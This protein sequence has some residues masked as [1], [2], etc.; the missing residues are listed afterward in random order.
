MAGPTPDKLLQ[1]A[2][3]RTEEGRNNA[4]FWLA[5]QLHD[6]EYVYPDAEM[7]MRRYA[8][9]VPQ[10][11][12]KDPYTEKEALKSLQ[13]AYKMDKR[14]A[15]SNAE[16]NARISYREQ[17]RQELQHKYGLKPPREAKQVDPEAAAR[18][19]A[20]LRGLKPFSGSPGEV[21]LIG[22]GIPAEI[23][24]TT[25]VK[26]APSW[27]GRP[28][29]VFP[30]CDSESKLVAAIGRYIDGGTPKHHFPKGMPKSEGLY[31]ADPEALECDPVAV[32]EAPIDALSIAVSGCPAIATGGTSWPE[33]LKRKLAFKTVFVATDS[34][35]PG[36]TAA[37]KLADELRPYGARPIRLRPG[38]KDW[39][40]VLT[41]DGP[42]V[43]SQA[44]IEA[45]AGAILE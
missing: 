29:V 10:H 12:G 6:N 25:R 33:W 1:M 8:G 37:G 18:F 4:G 2:L 39:N 19:H 45:Y 7:V 42:E 38:R 21:Y 30:F 16:G 36:E 31:L 44:T 11:P 28:A 15:W 34:D 9:S 26:Y 17:Q 27:Y 22:R 32:T 20:E 41:V 24:K 14:Q 35:E 5:Q 40:D 43:I 13:E 3:D 23:C